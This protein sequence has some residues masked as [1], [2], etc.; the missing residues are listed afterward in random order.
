MTHQ[1]YNIIDLFTEAAQRTPDRIAIIESEKRI[2]FSELDRQITATVAYFQAKGIRKG[3]RVLVFVPMS[4]DLY[5]IVLALFR[6]G[7][8]AVFLDEWVSRERL[9]ICC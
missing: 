8:T 9:N 5:R 4:I 6:M 2:S 3:D 7:A 1:H